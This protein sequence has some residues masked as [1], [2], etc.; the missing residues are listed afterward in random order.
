METFSAGP[1]SNRLAR[2]LDDRC[3]D[4]SVSWPYHP[5][6]GLGNAILD[7]LISE[8]A[9]ANPR[10]TEFEAA[11]TIQGQRNALR[12]G[13]R[14]RRKIDLVVDRSGR[15]PALAIE[16]KACMTAH[17]RA[18]SRLQAEIV[19]SLDAILDEDPQAAF[20]A[21]VVVNFGDRFTSPLNLP[22]PNIHAPTDAP[23][24]VDALSLGLSA[25]HEMRGVL[26]VPIKFDNE[27]G[28]ELVTTSLPAT[29]SPEGEF[30]SRIAKALDL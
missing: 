30:V 8:L 16:A 23:A 5:R 2:R 11:G 4:P 19:A 6:I 14:R 12:G 25:V 15:R 18:S 21:V 28:C 22:G 29:F 27:T 13:A 17:S 1:V 20:F 26:L 10:L 3:K 24:L 9:R 7:Y